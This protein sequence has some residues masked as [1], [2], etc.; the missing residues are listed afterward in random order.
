MRIF[1]GN[2]HKFK[3]LLFVFAGHNCKAFS[4]ISW[5]GLQLHLWLLLWLLL[6]LQL[7]LWLS[8]GVSWFKLLGT[9]RS[10]YFLTVEI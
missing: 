2:Y 7:R 8:G 5:L 1:I 4:R 10:N 6:G 9:K 3:L